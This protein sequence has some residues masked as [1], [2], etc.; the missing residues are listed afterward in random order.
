M[1]NLMNIKL[2][3]IKYIKLAL[4]LVLVSMLS[5]CL[6]N[7]SKPEANPPAAVAKQEPP[8]IKPNAPAKNEGA[9]GKA[10]T[11]KELEALNLAAPKAGHFLQANFEHKVEDA[12]IVRIKN[13]TLSYT[14]DKAG[15]ATK[16]QMTGF[17]QAFYDE[18]GNLVGISMGNSK[19]I[20]GKDSYNKMFANK[21]NS[22][23]AFKLYS[24]KTAADSTKYTFEDA[25]IKEGGNKAGIYID[26]NQTYVWRDPAVAGWNYQT[27]GFFNKQT[28]TGHDPSTGFQSIGVGTTQAQLPTEGKAVYNGYSMGLY[29][30]SGKVHD[31]IADVKVDVN[32]GKRQI[33]FISFNTKTYERTYQGEKYTLGA[34]QSAQ[35]LNLKASASFNTGDTKFSTTKVEVFADSDLKGRLNGRFYGDKAAEVGGTFGVAGGGK[36]YIGGFGAKRK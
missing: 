31:T 2:E 24:L 9:G 19:F 32:F 4:A 3:I 22:T 27:F 34:A 33:N 13:N 1:E 20:A 36:I 12:P 6:S 18:S 25:G 11:T 23:N 8:P 5:A 17:R 15:T 30:A 29:Q 28:V 10:D 7:P 16:P 35:Q 26:H 14:Y 21:L